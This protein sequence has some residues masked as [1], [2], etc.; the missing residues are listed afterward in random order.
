MRHKY[1]PQMIKQHFT[2][3]VKDICNLFGTNAKTVQRWISIEG[4]EPVAETRNPY[5][6]HGAALSAFLRERSK[7]SKTHLQPD[8]FY[9]VKCRTAR[10]GKPESTREIR[11]ETKMGR[12]K[13][14]GRKI[15]ICEVCGG[16]INR[17]F[18]YPMDEQADII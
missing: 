11:T 9:C 4:L 7:K 12:N 15:A 14:S 10:K 16:Q 8:E 5:L 1:N 3:T 17:F 6:I 2:Y 13:L 18:T